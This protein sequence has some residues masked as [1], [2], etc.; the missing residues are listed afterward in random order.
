MSATWVANAWPDRILGLSVVRSETSGSQMAWVD[1]PTGV[2]IECTSV[3][4]LLCYTKGR[5]VAGL[6]LVDIQPSVHGSRHV[7]AGPSV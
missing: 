7:L 5:Q 6:G 3:S 1:E 4:I 2:V